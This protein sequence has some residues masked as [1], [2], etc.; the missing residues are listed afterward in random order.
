MREGTR[1]KVKQLKVITVSWMIMGLLISVYD[2]LALQTHYSAG[3]AADYSFLVAAARNVGA[4][5][6][7]ALLGGS[8]MVFY[9]NDKLQDKPY[10]QTILVV[11]ISFL[12][13]V[14]FISLLMGLVLVPLKAGHSLHSLEGKR[15]LLAFLKD[16]SH[17]KAALAWSFVVGTTQLLLQ[18]N[19]KFGQSNFWNI[20]RGKYNQPK[21]EKKIF[22]FLDLN[23]S[24]TIAETLGDERYHSLL[25]DFFADI[26][27]PILD[28]K[29]SIYQYVGDEVVIAWNYEDGVEAE[30]CIRCFFDMKRHIQQRSA[31]YLKRYGLVPSFK[32]G[33]HCGRVVAGEVGII[34]RDITYSGDVLNTT[35]RILTKCSEL[36][37]E[38]I[39]SSEL[40]SAFQHTR[41]FITRPLGAIQLKG[42]SREVMLNSLMPA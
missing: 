31:K 4:G 24:T 21:E 33:I 40:L 8:L 36:Q 26:T 15:A 41:S 11:S 22:M 37:Q 13:I 1:L 27:V 7:G 2:Y 10:G 3:L 30:H 29:G 25:K 18:V 42:K 5:L 32:A 28:H 9:I 34:K 14:A 16:P 19:S 23:A 17:V 35:A 20:I 39:A 38:I 12:L 6:I